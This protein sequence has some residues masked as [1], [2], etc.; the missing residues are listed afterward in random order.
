MY[1]LVID[2]HKLMSSRGVTI[3][4]RARHLK[5]FGE[6]ASI[7]LKEKLL[8]HPLRQRSKRLFITRQIP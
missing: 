8:V 2:T 4:P 6:T 1:A 3:S 5:F 7:N